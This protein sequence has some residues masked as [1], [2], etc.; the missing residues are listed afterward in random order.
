MQGGIIPTQVL[1]PIPIREG[2]ALLIPALPRQG[3]SFKTPYTHSHPSSQ[4]GEALGALL[5][6][7]LTPD[8][9]QWKGTHSS[10]YLSSREMEYHT[11]TTRTR[12]SMARSLQPAGHMHRGAGGRKRQVQL[13]SASPLP[14]PG[15]SHPQLKQFLSRVLSWFYNRPRV[16]RFPQIPYESLAPNLC[17]H[18]SW[19]PLRTASAGPACSAGLVLLVALTG[20]ADHVS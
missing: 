1:L 5:P 3:E 18:H 17:P 10:M 13:Q 12:A 19:V 11:M 4:K 6:R 20:L 2:P 8:R 15:R 14:Q 9:N 16:S 7:A